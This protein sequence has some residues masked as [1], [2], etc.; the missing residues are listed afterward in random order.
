MINIRC[1]CL[2]KPLIIQL[3]FHALPVC[4]SYSIHISSSA[5][6]YFSLSLSVSF[7]VEVTINILFLQGIYE[8]ITQKDM[9]THT[10]THT[11][12]QNSEAKKPALCRGKLQRGAWTFS[13]FSHHFPPDFLFLLFPSLTHQFLVLLLSV[14]AVTATQNLKKKLSL[15]IIEHNRTHHLPKIPGDDRVSQGSYLSAMYSWCV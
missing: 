4:S 3:Q 2:S 7:S 5:M 1:V 8:S 15:W 11:H 13:L 9:Y 14:S 12:L 6:H 10:H